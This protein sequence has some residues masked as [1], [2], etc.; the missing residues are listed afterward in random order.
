[1]IEAVGEEQV[2]VNWPEKIL[3]KISKATGEERL[4]LEMTMQALQIVPIAH[5]HKNMK[6]LL[7]LQTI[8]KPLKDLIP[9]YDQTLPVEH[10]KLYIDYD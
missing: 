7:P 9:K 2:I 6:P 3:R 4:E 10:T 8:T 1:M 5:P